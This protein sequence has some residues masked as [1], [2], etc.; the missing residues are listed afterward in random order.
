MLIATE[1]DELSNEVYKIYSDQV[2]TLP[3]NACIR[4]RPASHY[5]NVNDR[6]NTG[7]GRIKSGKPGICFNQGLLGV[8]GNIKSKDP[9]QQLAKIQ[10]NKEI[11]ESKIHN[12]FLAENFLKRELIESGHINEKGKKDKK[13]VNKNRKFFGDRE[14]E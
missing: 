14:I 9:K 8:L 3:L 12:P 1:Y 5:Q 10:I 2:T 11:E 7:H 13:I 4:K 6:C